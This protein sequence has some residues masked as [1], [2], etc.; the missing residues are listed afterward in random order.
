MF[1]HQK[2]ESVNKTSTKLYTSNS[3][4]DAQFGIP[5]PT[6]CE[7][8]WFVVALASNLIH[9]HVPMDYVAVSILLKI[10]GRNVCVFCYAT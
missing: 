8:M 9:Y 6:W 3:G 2:K 4:F 5:F 7:C 10:S 1:L